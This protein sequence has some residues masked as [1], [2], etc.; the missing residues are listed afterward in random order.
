M[1]LP[2]RFTKIIADRDEN[3][4][5]GDKLIAVVLRRSG[6]IQE[7]LEAVC[8][9]IGHDFLEA[10]SVTTQHWYKTGRCCRCEAEKP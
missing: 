4:I 9:E 10:Y 5:L 6:L 3:L 8:A 1:G 7:L 2:E